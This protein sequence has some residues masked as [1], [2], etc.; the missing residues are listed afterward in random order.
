VFVPAREAENEAFRLKYS[1]FL[2]ELSDDTLI[3]RSAK[4]TYRFKAGGS[5]DEDKTQLREVA[6]AIARA[7]R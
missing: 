4:R 1:E 2:D 6:D 5:R 3:L 7:R